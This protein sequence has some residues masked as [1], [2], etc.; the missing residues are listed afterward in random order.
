[1]TTTK[2]PVC[3]DHG[4]LMFPGRVDS[5]TMELAWVCLC[6]ADGGRPMCQAVSPLSK[7]RCE[8]PDLHRRTDKTITHQNGQLTWGEVDPGVWNNLDRQPHIDT[9]S[10][11]D[12]YKHS[13]PLFDITSLK[14]VFLNDRL[15]AHAYTAGHE[16]TE[17]II[18]EMRQA[19]LA[20]WWRDT[21]EA[22]ISQTVAKAIEYGSTDLIDIGRSIARVAD[23]EVEDDEAAEMGIFFY[24]EGKL[25]RWRSALE[26]GDRPSDDTLL[27]IGVYARMAQR[28]R[29]SGGWPGVDDNEHTYQQNTYGGEPQ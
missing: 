10:A 20:Q 24:L 11:T 4:Q 28:I 21:A 7:R 17:T 3:P 6:T 15:Q 18:D 8:K 2:V 25:S 12:N 27:D 19:A 5:D 29:H 16:P 14:R 13:G 23:L 22:E 9:T 1:M 26:R